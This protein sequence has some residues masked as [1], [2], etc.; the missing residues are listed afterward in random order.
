MRLHR[1][2]GQ[3]RSEVVQ[4]A[5][6]AP[7]ARQTPVDMHSVTLT[8]QV[9]AAQRAGLVIVAHVFWQTPYMAE[10]EFFEGRHASCAK[11]LPPKHRALMRAADD[12]EI[13]FICCLATWTRRTVL[14]ISLGASIR[15]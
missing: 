12:S 2:G 6:R 10:H 1:A 9:A 5:F 14:G 7:R 3:L 15:T 8:S 11:A 13:L 4:Q